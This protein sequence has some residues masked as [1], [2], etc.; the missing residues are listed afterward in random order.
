MQNEEIKR[1]CQASN[2]LKSGV[3]SYGAL[4]HVPLLD[5]QQYSVLVHFRVNLAA[6]Y[7]SSLLCSLRE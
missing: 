6:S 5:F 4:G 2:Q 3:A 7:P 1:L